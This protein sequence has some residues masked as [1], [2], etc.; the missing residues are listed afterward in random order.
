MA[1]LSIF[2]THSLADGTL[3]IFVT[4]SLAD[5]TR[6]LCHPQSS[7]W[8][9]R[10][11]RHPQSSWWHTR[12]LCQFSRGWHSDHCLCC[13][14]TKWVGKDFVWEYIHQTDTRNRA[15]ISNNFLRRWVRERNLKQKYKG[16]II[17]WPFPWDKQLVLL[18]WEHCW[19]TNT[20]FHH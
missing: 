7:W 16:T 11:L 5:D 12:N 1:Q 3:A 4:R 9:T 19:K 10:N 18:S 20:C 6:Y 13:R 2:V 17:M 14:S 8:H 15:L